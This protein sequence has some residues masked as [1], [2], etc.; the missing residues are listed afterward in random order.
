MGKEGALVGLH[1]ALVYQCPGTHQAPTQLKARIII[2]FSESLKSAYRHHGG[3][4]DAVAA[5]P[6]SSSES[7]GQRVCWARSGGGCDRSVQARALRRC[8]R[9]GMATGTSHEIFAVF[10]SQW[11]TQK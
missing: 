7:R 3:Q 4:R 10:G 1:V 6:G 5:V 11:K 2:Y 9:R 8:G